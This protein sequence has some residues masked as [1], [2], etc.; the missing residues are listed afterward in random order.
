MLICFHRHPLGLRPLRAEKHEPILS[1]CQ[2]HQKVT[3]HRARPTAR[4]TPNREVMWPYTATLPSDT[5]LP[6]SL[7]TCLAREQD[8]HS[9]THPSP[10]SRRQ[11]MHVACEEYARTRNALLH[12]L[13]PQGNF[14]QAQPTADISKDEPTEG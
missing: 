2:V 1:L 10:E 4:T 6:L 11:S 9:S 14:V 3:G 13:P 7:F 12:L 8:N 5:L